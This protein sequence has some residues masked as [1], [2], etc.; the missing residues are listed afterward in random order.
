[1]TT[2]LAQTTNV[3]M[4]ITDVL[5]KILSIP[6]SYRLFG[7]IIGDRSEVWRTY[8]AEYVKPIPGSKVLDIGCGP[9]DALNFLPQM[10]YTGL[11]IS[12]KYIESA[13]NRFANRGRF[14]CKD[15]GLATISG[16]E[17][18]FDLVL[19]TGVVHHLDDD[20]AGRLFELARLALR[21]S[22]RLVAFDGCYVPEQSG[23]ARWLLSRDRGK[24]VRAQA[25]Y[26]R[27]AS[28]RFKK[29]ESHLRH[30]LLRIPYTHHV[31]VCSNTSDL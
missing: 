21:P 14:W 17:G 31:M 15:V 25:D 12:S 11:D 29:V 24:F 7:R 27:L 20:T 22:G 28:N 13:K 8:L 23:I 5:S 2:S 19:A 26:V 9:A 3:S 4:R 30:D 6:G 18:T 10:D 16:E 1:M